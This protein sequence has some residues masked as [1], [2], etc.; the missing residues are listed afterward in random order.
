MIIIISTE[1]GVTISVRS[2]QDG[3]ALTMGITVSELVETGRWME[4]KSAMMGM[5]SHWMDVTRI[6]PP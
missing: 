2:K 1:T 6:V 4:Q 5:K 3:L